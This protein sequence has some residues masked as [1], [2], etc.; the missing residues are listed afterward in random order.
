MKIV[1]SIGNNTYN[2][3]NFMFASVISEHEQLN[4]CLDNLSIFLQ[5]VKYRE[6]LLTAQLLVKLPFFIVLNHARKFLKH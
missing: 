6:N 1:F 5:Q 4:I 2:L 3:S